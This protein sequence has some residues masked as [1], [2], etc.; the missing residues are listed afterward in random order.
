LDGLENDFFLGSWTMI[1]VE[2]FKAHKALTYL[3]FIILVLLVGLYLA[4]A[5]FTVFYCFKRIQQMIFRIKDTAKISPEENVIFYINIRIL[6]NLKV[7]PNQHLVLKNS[8]RKIRKKILK[9]FLI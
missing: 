5:V 2:I 9:K 4:Y 7:S 1:S 6:K 8:I 3:S